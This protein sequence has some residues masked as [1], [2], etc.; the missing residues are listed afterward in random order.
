[1]TEIFYRLG[2]SSQ[3]MCSEAFKDV[4]KLL[5]TE[6]RKLSGKGVPR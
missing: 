2:Y 3:G 5:P 4:T 6:Y 1:M